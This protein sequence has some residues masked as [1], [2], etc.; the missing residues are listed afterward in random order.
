MIVFTGSW[1]LHHKGTHGSFAQDPRLSHPPSLVF[2]HQYTTSNWFSSVRR[3][4][5]LSIIPWVLSA[6]D[7]QQTDWPQTTLYILRVATTLPFSTAVVL[8]WTSVSFS[9]QSHSLLSQSIS[10]QASFALHQL[11]IILRHNALWINQNLRRPSLTIKDDQ[12]T[13]QN[14]NRALWYIYAAPSSLLRQPRSPTAIHQS[15]LQLYCTRVWATISQNNWVYR[16]LSLLLRGILSIPN[17]RGY[18]VDELSHACM[19]EK[20]LGAGHTSN[21]SNRECCFIVL[22]WI[23]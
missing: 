3:Q 9:P 6:F 5:I 11:R 21:F 12:V 17:K 16:R 14:E 13:P 10:K 23:N 19:Q 15:N 18:W 1:E 7:P 2:E 8:T 22:P 20:L 4:A